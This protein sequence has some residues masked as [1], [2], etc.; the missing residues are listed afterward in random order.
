MAK[1]KQYEVIANALR[2]DR[3][4]EIQRL[5]AVFVA[6]TKLVFI[7]IFSHFICIIIFYSVFYW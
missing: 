2:D 1:H 6:L 4:A 5:F 3:A 7:N